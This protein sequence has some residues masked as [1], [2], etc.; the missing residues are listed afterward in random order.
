MG[1]GVDG[2]FVWELVRTWRRRKHEEWLARVRA[3]RGPCTVAAGTFHSLGLRPDGSVACWGRNDDGQ[4]PPEGVPGPFVH[5]AAGS[6]HSLGLTTPAMTIGRYVA[7]Y[8]MR[9][10]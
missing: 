3:L 1:A 7:K 6:F 9:G 10:T 2:E 8:V 4:A 5:V